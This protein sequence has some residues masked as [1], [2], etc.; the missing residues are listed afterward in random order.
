MGRREVFHARKN[1]VGAGKGTLVYRKK[2]NTSS[3]NSNYATDFLVDVI[4]PSSKDTDQPKTHFCRAK[5]SICPSLALK[6]KL[7]GFYSVA[8]VL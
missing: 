8:K 4:G 6:K 5:T 2:E 1:A 7:E 3:E